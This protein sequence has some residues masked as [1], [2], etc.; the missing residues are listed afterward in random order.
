MNRTWLIVPLL[1]LAACQNGALPE[2]TP[3]RVVVESPEP[4]A[5]V[6]AVLYPGTVVA[7]AES[8]LAFRIPGQLVVRHVDAG[9]RVKAGQPLAEIDPLD[10]QLALQAAQ[11]AVT[12]AEADLRL[13]ESELRRHRDLLARGFISASAFELRENQARL[14]EARLAQA[15]ADAAV[16]RNQSRYTVL[17]AERDGLVTAALAEVGQVLAA[18]A[19]VLRFVPDEGR[20]VEIQIPEGRLDDLTDAALEV[21]LWALPEARYRG[22]VREITPQADPRTR[23]HRVRIALTDADARVQLGMTANVSLAL[24]AAQPLFGVPR[25]AVGEAEG[26][27]AVWRVVETVS[28]ERVAPVPVRVV[29]YVES[30]VVV[31]AEL[32]PEDRLVSA[33]VHLLRPDEPVRSV[34]RQQAAR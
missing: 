17:R 10:A 2:P 24:P 4:L 20:E 21:R 29:R 6:G 8:L 5:A 25:T 27:P 26:Q 32:T 3:R 14:A 19:P 31:E 23:T 28:G 16:M 22:E 33:G 12:A 7:R 13:A 11:A 18:G 34:P 9:D 1:G 30:G 15:R